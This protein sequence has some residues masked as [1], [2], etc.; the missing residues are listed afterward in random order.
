MRSI[1]VAPS[2]LAADFQRL[3]EEGATMRIAFFAASP[4]STTKPTWVRMLLSCPPSTTPTSRSLMAM[5]A[6]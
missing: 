6:L 5:E 1:I 3:G 4:I 2:I